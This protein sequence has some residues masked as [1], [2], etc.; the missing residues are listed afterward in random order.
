MVFGI[1]TDI[2]K[3]ER[4]R[5]ILDG[6]RGAFITKTFTEKERLQA[7]ERGDPV[8]YYATRFAGKEAVYKCF[9]SVA[10]ALN[11]TEIEILNAETGQP[12]VSLGGALRELASRKGIKKI[13]L[14]LSYETEYAVA[15]A[16][17]QE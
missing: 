12:Q 8:I 4:I 13:H 17:A 10:A 6:D 16:V 14:S 1:G 2:L 9:G 5:D 7:S 15:F 11:L 3:V